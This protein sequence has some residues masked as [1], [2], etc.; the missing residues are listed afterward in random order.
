VKIGLKG[1][2]RSNLFFFSL[3]RER[4]KN[5]CYDKIKELGVDN[6]LFYF[7]ICDHHC[8]VVSVHSRVLNLPVSIFANVSS[9]LISNAVVVFVVLSNGTTL[10]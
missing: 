1:L 6:Q 8:A 2:K 3:I 9:L 7:V 4:D 5:Q 10:A